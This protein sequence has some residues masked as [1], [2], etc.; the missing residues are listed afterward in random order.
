MGN[1]KANVIYAIGTDSVL[2]YSIISPKN[3]V[4]RCKTMVTEAG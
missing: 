2:N 1:A 4:P 3:K